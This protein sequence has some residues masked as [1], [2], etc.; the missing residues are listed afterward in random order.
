VAVRPTTNTAYDGLVSDVRTLLVLAPATTLLDA[1][2]HLHVS[3][4]TLTRALAAM[5]LT[6]RAEQRAVQLNRAASLLLER[7]YANQRVALLSA[8][9]A[10]GRSQPRHLCEP[11]RLVFGATPGQVWAIGCRIRSL[12]ALAMAPHPKARD[13]PAAYQRRRRRRMRLEGDLQRWQRELRPDT[14]I[15]AA[16]DQALATASRPQSL[17]RSR[18]RRRGRARPRRL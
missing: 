10:I 2:D 11:F 12:R 15:T 14:V 5:G 6:F 18:A 4:R 9:R 17:R 3:E 7:S 16:I 1:A 8:T 13:D